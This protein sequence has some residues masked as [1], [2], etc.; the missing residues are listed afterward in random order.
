M[1]TKRL[2]AFPWFGGKAAPKI[3]NTLLSFLPPH[4]KYIEP[5]GGGASV[6]INHPAA[7]VEVYNDVNRGIVN[8]FRVVAD[9][10]LFPHFLARV[11]PM[12]FSRE[13]WE[14]YARTWP[15]IH[16]S[17][18]QAVRWYYV[19]RGSFGG[20]FGNAWG[21]T[22]NSSSSGMASSVRRW[23]AAVDALPELHER[24]MRVQIE[25]CD[26][27]V[28]LDRYAGRG[29]LAYCDPP[30]VLG[31]R[32]S[33]GYEQELTVHDHRE[34]VDT[35][36]E[37]DGAVVLSGYRTRLYNPLE[38]AG[39]TGTE[40]DVVCS[41]VGRTRANGLQGKGAAKAKQKRVEVIWRNPEAMSRLT[42]F[43]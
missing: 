13:L 36:L 43:P 1:T 39:W 37:Y 2:C 25:C 7:A 20:I 17:I 16:D 32:R 12:P 22:T 21:A 23:L 3:L 10:R 30:Y 28:V 40:V 18:E 42:A 4:D 19:A 34:L 26:W 41:A 35:L 29:W 31:A 38:E 15:G 11:Q 14:E 5:F 9:Q 6:L 8:F 24:M 33:G 27:R